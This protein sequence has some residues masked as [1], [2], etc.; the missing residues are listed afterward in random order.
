MSCRLQVKNMTHRPR[1]CS[2]KKLNT[3][4]RQLHPLSPAVYLNKLDSFEWLLYRAI[5]R[6]QGWLPIS[7]IL[8]KKPLY[9]N[10]FTY[11]MEFY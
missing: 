11:L 8:K 5:D 10:I 9:T 7:F 1:E 6:K 3:V 4:E 2:L